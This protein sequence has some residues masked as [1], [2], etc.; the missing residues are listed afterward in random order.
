MWEVVGR[1]LDTNL[2]EQLLPL[3]VIFEFDF[4]L[5]FTTF[6]GSPFLCGTYRALAH[7]LCDDGQLFRFIVVAINEVLL[8]ALKNRRVDLRWVLEQPEVW[9]ADINNKSTIASLWAVSFENIPKEVLPK[10]GAMA[11]LEG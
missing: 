9:I 7:Y 11:T 5:T 4:P 6:V 2:L 3:E 10:P 8:N 1:K